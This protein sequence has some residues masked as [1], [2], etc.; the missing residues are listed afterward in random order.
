[1]ARPE[2]GQVAEDLHEGLGLNGLTV[3]DEDRDWPLLR[4][5]EVLTGGALEQVHTY[6]AFRN[7]QDGFVAVFDP[8]TTPT[9]ALAYVGQF[10]GTR[11]DASLDEAAK[12][13]AIALPR[14]F[15]RGRVTALIGAVQPTLTGT[16]LVLVEERYTGAAYQMRVRTLASE[17]PVPTLVA[18]TVRK[19]M[20]DLTPTEQAI[21][22][23]KVIGT[24]LTYQ[25]I[26]GGDWDDL[27]ADF[28]DWDALAAAE[29][30][31]NDVTARLP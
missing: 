30:T 27:V 22:S 24:V 28:A 1:M 7:G 25:S 2:V 5:C 31:W 18:R 21:V 26:V 29:D 11:F 4:F 3:G 9:E 15:K 8:T 6:A 20:T 10:T 19:G 23:Q 14:G 12:R 17:T 13:E 16:Q